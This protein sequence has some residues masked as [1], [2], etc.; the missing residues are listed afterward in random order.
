MLIKYVYNVF[1]LISII[2][3]KYYKLLI[4]YFNNIIQAFPKDGSLD[5][6]FK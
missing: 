3:Y 1:T 4:L 5:H 6:I 2:N